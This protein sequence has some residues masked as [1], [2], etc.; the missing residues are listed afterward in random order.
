MGRRTTPDTAVDTAIPITPLIDMTFQLLIFFMCAMKFKTLARKVHAFL[1]KDRGPAHYVV[2]FKD[3]LKLSVLLLRGAGEAETRVKFLDSDL[4]AGVAAFDELTARL[5]RVHEGSGPQ[6]PGGFIDA[7]EEVPHRDVMR[8]L[9]SFLKA[10]VT[11]VQF[12]GTAP[13]GR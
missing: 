12:K 13:P 10:G 5:K 3:D 11:D 7:L 1:P 9:D 2:D 4:G 6:G 8:C